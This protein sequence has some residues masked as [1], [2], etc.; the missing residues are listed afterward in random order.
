MKPAQELKF[1]FFAQLECCKN[2]LSQLDLLEFYDKTPSPISS[3]ASFFRDKSY[4]EEWDYIYKNN[5]AHIK[6]RDL[7]MFLFEYKNN[8]LTYRYYENPHHFITKE[9][10]IKEFEVYDELLYEQYL[11][12]SPKQYVT[13]IKYDFFPKDYVPGSHPASH[14]HFGVDNNIRIG[15]SHILQPIAFVLFIVRLVYPDI[16]INYKL[17]NKEIVNLETYLDTLS[18]V[19][20]AIEDCQELCLSLNKIRI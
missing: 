10:F 3:P 19:F 4:L 13:P 5:C 15:C 8:A 20:F 7:S 9:E 11:S 14:F 1:N 18:T 12:E 17:Y 2:F 16:W 6:L